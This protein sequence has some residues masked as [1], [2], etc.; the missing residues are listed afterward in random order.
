LKATGVASSLIMHIQNY[1][2]IESIPKL[3][4]KEKKKNWNGLPGASWEVK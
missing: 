2:S 1:T 4:N 3:Q